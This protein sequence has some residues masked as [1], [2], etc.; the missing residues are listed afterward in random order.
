MDQS[1][2]TCCWWHPWETWESR[3]GGEIKLGE[4]RRHSP[5]ILDTALDSYEFPRTDPDVWCG[6][7]EE[8]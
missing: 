1:C 7:W 6:D 5:V 8:R 3:H 4:C 2:A